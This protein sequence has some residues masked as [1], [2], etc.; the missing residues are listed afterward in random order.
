[1]LKALSVFYFET[2]LIEK[3]KPSKIKRGKTN[4][5]LFVSSQIVRKGVSKNILCQ[6][7]INYLLKNR[8]RHKNLLEVI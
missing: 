2:H 5:L 1:M 7:I 4:Q 6:S 8:D 3:T